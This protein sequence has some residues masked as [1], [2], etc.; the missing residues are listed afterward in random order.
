[1]AAKRQVSLDPLLQCGHPALLQF[2]DPPL[3]GA[4]QHDIGKRQPRHTANISLM[5][6]AVSAARPTANE[7]RASV[8]GSSSV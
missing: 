6:L 5:R 4:E 8:M 1:M 7:A 2:G 3:A